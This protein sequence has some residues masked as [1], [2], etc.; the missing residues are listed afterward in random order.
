M[1]Q[2]LTQYYL[3]CEFLLICF[4]FFLCTSEKQISE[5][6]KHMKVIFYMQSTKLLFKIFS[7][8]LFSRCFKDINTRS[9]LSNS[10]V[11]D[12]KCER[13]RVLKK[14]MC[15]LLLTSTH[16]Q[17]PSKPVRDTSICFLVGPPSEERN[18]E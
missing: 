11:S 6:G 12:L 10:L 4:F 13:K 15:P 16:I 1:R 8:V 5:R 9:I 17:C 2:R 18:E 7:R 14:S 3:S